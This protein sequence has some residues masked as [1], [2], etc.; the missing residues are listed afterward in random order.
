MLEEFVRPRFAASL[1]AAH[2]R[3]STL[4]IVRRLGT[5]SIGRCVDKA[6]LQQLMLQYHGRLHKA[7]A[8]L[9]C[10]ATVH[11]VYR[12]SDAKHSVVCSSH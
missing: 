10:G 8:A 2:A 6:I 12:T 9:R 5:G 11:G 4:K 3:L 7:V 1:T